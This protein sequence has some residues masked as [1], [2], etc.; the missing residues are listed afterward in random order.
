[1]IIRKKEIKLITNSE[2]ETEWYE[3]DQWI[4]G[5][6]SLDNIIS[7]A[8]SQEITNDIDRE[9]LSSLTKSYP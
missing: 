7:R 6:A 2:S 3:N 9:I 5:T 8:M 4:R 1:M